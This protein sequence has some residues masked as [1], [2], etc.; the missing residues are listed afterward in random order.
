M[1]T[2]R[3]RALSMRLRGYS[4]NEIQRK[5]GIPKSTLSNWFVNIPLSDAAQKRLVGKVHQGTLN[6]LVRRN[7]DQTRLA[8]IPAAALREEAKNKIPFLSLTE[9]MIIGAVLYWAEGYKRSLVRNGK[10]RTGHSISFLNADPRMIQIFLKFL[11]EIMKIQKEKICLIMRLYPN[12][13]EAEAFH[14]WKGVTHM[15][16]SCF[17]KST[18]LISSASK[19]KRPSDRLPYGTLQVAVYDTSKFHTLMGLIEGVK[20]KF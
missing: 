20:N 7:K 16:N 14:Y 15:P 9:L 6:G 18:Y 12:L 5:F 1:H 8:I 2:V 19:G 13:S 10:E 11:L 3:K 17:R 4:Y